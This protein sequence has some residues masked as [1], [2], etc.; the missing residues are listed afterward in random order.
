MTE[1]DKLV[2]GLLSQINIKLDTMINLMSSKNQEREK[3]PDIILFRREESVIPGPRNTSSPETTPLPILKTKKK[4]PTLG[5]SSR[6]YSHYTP[7]D[8]S[9]GTENL[10]SM[11]SIDSD[12]SDNKNTFQVSNFQDYQPESKRLVVGS[13]KEN[14][15]KPIEN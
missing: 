2:I 13:K 6:T 12:F 10:G 14:I 7:G 3:T 4:R 9:S 8:L 11:S 1:N 5:E 15:S